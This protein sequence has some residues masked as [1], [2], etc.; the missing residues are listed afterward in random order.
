M[1]FL[2]GRRGGLDFRKCLGSQRGQLLTLSPVFFVFVFFFFHQAWLHW[3]K[4]LGGG[5]G[6][7][8]FWEEEMC[9]CGG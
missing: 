7:G 1:D 3:R 4:G 6:G 2:C 9:V 8:V 5:G